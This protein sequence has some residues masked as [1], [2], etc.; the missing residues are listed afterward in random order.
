MVNT[1]T[2]KNKPKNILGK[3]LVLCSNT[4]KTGYFRNGYCV[5]GPTNS[6]THVVCAKVTDEFLQYSKSQDNDLITPGPNFPGLKAGDKWCLCAYRWLEAYKAGV[7]PPVVLESTN[8]AVKTIIP[9][10][11]L[12]KFAVKTNTRNKSLKI[13]HF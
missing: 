12:K 8:I 10:S 1:N 13:A 5:T 11:I 4:P 6:G 2:R 9:V 7:A 3:N